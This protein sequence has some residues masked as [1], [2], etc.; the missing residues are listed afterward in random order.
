MQLCN[1]FVKNWKW[2]G[3][4]VF[5]FLLV[6]LIY[7]WFTPTKVNVMGK[8]QIIDR[9]KRSGQL[10]M[11]MSMLNSL[12]MGLGSSLGGSL[13]ALGGGIESEEEIL[14]SNNLSRDVVNELGLYTEYRLSSW[15]RKTLLYQNQPVNVTISPVDL[16]KLEDKLPLKLIQIKL[17][18]TKS[19]D[20]Y[21]VETVVKENKENTE[22]PDQTFAK[23]PATIDTGYGTLVLSENPLL[24]DEDIENYQKGYTLKVNILPASERAAE[25]VEHLTV[26][27]PL[28]KAPDMVEV[29]IEDESVVRG[30]DF[31]STLVD[32]YNKRVNAE[33]NE[34][35]LK[36][37]EFVNQRLANLDVEL[38]LSDAAWE[39]SKKNFQVTDPKVD[40]QEII[41]K[42]SFY[43]TQLVSI[44]VQLQLQDYLKVYVDNLDNLFEL[45]PVNVGMTDE[46]IPTSGDALPMI[47]RHNILV[48]QRKDLLKSMSEQAPQVQR[49]TETIRELQ[50]SI[51]T[52]ILRDRESILIRRKNVEREY[53]KYL[54]R[55][56][57]APQMERVLTEI[58]RQREIKQGVYLLMLQQREETAMTLAN[59]TDKGKLIDAVRMVKNS[60]HPKKKIVLLAALFLGL[61]FPMPFLFFRLTL[62]PKCRNASLVILSL[63]MMSSCMSTK[64]V[65]YFTNMDEVDTNSSK[66][67]YDAKI[68]PK[69]ILQIKVFSVTPGTSELFN[70][71]KNL[72]T[73]STSVASNQNSV[74]NYFVDNNGNIVFPVV[75]T[76]H[77]GGLTQNEAENLIKSKIAPYMSVSEDF[78]V[79]V[80]MINY[81][82]S[83]LGEVRNPGT[84]NAQNEKVN[85]LEAIAQ[86]GDLTLYGMRN[87]IYLIREDSE[88]RK[89]FHRLN[90]ND[91]NIISSPYYY[92]Q[93][94]DIIYVEPNKAQARSS[95]FSTSSSI[96]MSITSALVSL[97]TLIIA[98]TK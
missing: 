48:N 54:G 91:A 81:K 25:F 87:K 86:A 1:H 55:V 80:R 52:A 64:N 22:L 40:A 94:N 38:G 71:E 35:A 13:G 45:I 33:K 51:Q 43:E 19:G 75:G 9:S 3:I 88:G 90:L 23:L 53:S 24:E 70:L 4:S 30:A 11:G 10:S 60:K 8:M 92:L 17:T 39:K 31:V 29:T 78:L 96:W 42:K 46:N 50:P 63:I 76:I 18:I 66:V 58:G 67:L 93:Q 89:E 47:S 49:L 44:G 79:H 95:Y 41:E 73:T 98:I 27:Q 84:F 83:V 16:K 14:M 34:E 26:E 68:M 32:L 65:P 77:L 28:S 85:I 2:F 37:D 74:Y 7:L 21:T 69:D 20:N 12:P 6:A 97:S 61:L 15:G 72:N 56:S 59:I 57:S 82:Y 62:K 36:T 5:A